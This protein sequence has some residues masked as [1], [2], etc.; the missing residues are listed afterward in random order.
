MELKTYFTDFLSNIRPTAAQNNELKEGHTLLRT[1]LQE[2]DDLKSIV[3]DTFL[4]GSYRRYTAIRPK[5]SEKGDVDVI[6]V[7]NIDKDTVAPNEAL[8]M[9]VPF[10]DKYYKGKYEFQGRSLGIEMSSIK[11]DLVPTSAPSEVGKQL[12]KSSMFT[13][14]NPSI[15]SILQS[16]NV[17]FGSTAMLSEMAKADKEFKDHPLYIPDV[18][19]DEWEETDP[20]SQIRITNEKNSECNG[21]YVNVVKAIKW[22]RREMQPEPKYPKSYPLEHLICLN[23]PDAIT[24]VAIGVTLTL[25][26]ISAA[27][28]TQALIKQTPFISDHGV[29]SHDVLGRVS[30]DDFAKFHSHI[31]EAAVIA[32]KAFDAQTEKKSAIL[33]RKLF[34]DNF[35]PPSDN[36]DND[37]DDGGGPRGGY[38]PRTKESVI[39]GGGRF[40]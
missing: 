22:W 21:H 18:D 28:Y 34:G 26:R 2:Y 20:V 30:G 36:G 35:P 15:D 25:E 11:L 37:E 6:V 13:E 31:S 8:Q 7:T 3:V 5:P 17:S 1:R 19:A 29:P 24:S 33:W 9:F 38:S 14:W 40:A 10:L 12:L 23:C 16:T 39:T 27:Y 4:Q 32:R